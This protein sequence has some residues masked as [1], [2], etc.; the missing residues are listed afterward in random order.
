M[1]GALLCGGRSAARSRSASRRLGI[2]ED[3]V[4]RSGGKSDMIAA[5]ADGDG[6]HDA[7]RRRA[8]SGSSALLGA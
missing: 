2:G 8:W 7:G 1:A 6:W 4:A 5:A 3:C